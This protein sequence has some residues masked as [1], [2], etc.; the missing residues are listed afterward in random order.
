[1]ACVRVRVSRR[2]AARNSSQVRACLL[3]ADPGLQSPHTVETEYRA[4]LRKKRVCPLP[5]WCIDIHT[6]ETSG[7]IEAC[8][9]HTNDQKAPAIEVQ[10][11]AENVRRRVEFPLPEPFT[12]DR[13][14]RSSNF[15]LTGR[16]CTADQRLPPNHVQ[17]IGR[18]K[19][20]L[21]LLGLA[22]S[23]EIEVVAAIQAH[24]GECA[25]LFLP[26]LEIRPGNG[27]AREIRFALGEPDELF[28]LRVGQWLE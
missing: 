15:V 21:Q 14:W 23:G 20:R 26:I 13:N 7:K 22:M 19:P 24:S 5:H 17:E 4:S 28:R 1:N 11:L 10:T 3:D 18:K 9:K 25:V 6:T 12:D 16:E 8:R 27:P 2:E